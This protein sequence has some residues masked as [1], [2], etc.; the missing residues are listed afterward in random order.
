VPVAYEVEPLPHGGQVYRPLVGD[1]APIAAR[2][3]AAVLRSLH[4]NAERWI[5][6]NDSGWEA[7][8]RLT[9]MADEIDPKEPRDDRR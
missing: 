3:A 5:T 8:G 6:S 7:A 2:Q 9:R 4:A 1:P